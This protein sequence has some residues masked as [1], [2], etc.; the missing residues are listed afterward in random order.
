MF[1]E[2]AKRVWSVVNKPVAW[3][4]TA[5]GVGAMIVTAAIEPARSLASTIVV[6][7]WSFLFTPREMRPVW[8]ALLILYAVFSAAWQFR[9]WHER[10][11]G[12]GREQTFEFDAQ[13]D[14]SGRVLPLAIGCRWKRNFRGQ[15]TAVE[16]RCPVCFHAYRMD[17]PHPDRVGPRFTRFA[18][19]E[20]GYG[21]TFVGAPDQWLE[22]LKRSAYFYVRTG[23]VPKRTYRG[24]PPAGGP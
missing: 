13:A 3:L 18:C 11:P 19:V 6:H 4:F 17:D 24:L 23:V 20:C 15:I 8:L 2:R 5:G 14:G 21:G 7:A 10:R 9:R 16:A 12:R 22:A 1:K